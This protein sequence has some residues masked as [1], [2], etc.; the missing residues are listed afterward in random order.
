MNKRKHHLFG[1][2][3]APVVLRFVNADAPSTFG[4]SGFV[5][6]FCLPTAVW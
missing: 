4:N 2:F 1:V 6:R 5:N 3:F